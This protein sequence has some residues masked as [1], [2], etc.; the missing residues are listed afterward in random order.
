MNFCKLQS[1]FGVYT[2]LRDQA[3]D[4]ELRTGKTLLWEHGPGRGKT[5]P[6]SDDR[7]RHPAHWFPRLL[8]STSPPPSPRAP[9]S[10]PR[11]GDHRV[12]PDYSRRR[13]R[14]AGPERSR[15]FPRRPWASCTRRAPRRPLHV[16]ATTRCH[17][18][19]PC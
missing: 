2:R 14:L 8:S 16:P 19:L 11:V 5:R 10:P 17:T 1:D 6:E 7:P 13:R 3:T 4:S 9:A 15:S 12:L 18:P